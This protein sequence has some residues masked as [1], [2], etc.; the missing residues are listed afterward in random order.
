MGVGLLCQLANY[1]NFISD[2]IYLLVTN[3]TSLN[4]SCEWSHLINHSLQ[5]AN[6]FNIFSEV[7]IPRSILKKFL[8]TFGDFT[9]H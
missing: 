2:Q 3:V 7:T 1:F 8:Q 6:P 9:K 5:M 4:Q